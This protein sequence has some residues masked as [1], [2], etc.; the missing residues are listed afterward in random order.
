[1]PSNP[2][3]RVEYR[4]VGEERGR[5]WHGQVSLHRPA[6]DHMAF[7]GELLLRK[8]E[9]KATREQGDDQRVLRDTLLGGALGDLLGEP[10]WHP[11]EFLGG[12]SVSHDPQGSKPVLSSALS[13]NRPREIAVSGGMAKG[14]WS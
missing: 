5:P 14:W 1:M 8:F 10:P 11:Y 7:M 6:D 13:T 3:P 2:Q 12:V 9:A 4:V